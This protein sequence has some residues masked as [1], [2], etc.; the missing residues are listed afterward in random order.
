MDRKYVSAMNSFNE[1]LNSQSHLLVKI[2]CFGSVNSFSWIQLQN[3]LPPCKG[4]RSEG[5]HH[6][7]LFKTK[8]VTP[9][10]L[11]SE[12]AERYA[13]IYVKTLV[14]QHFRLWNPQTP[15][16]PKFRPSNRHWVSEDGLPEPSSLRDPGPPR[17]KPPLPPM[18][19]VPPQC[20][21]PHPPLLPN[22][23]FTLRS[24]IQKANPP[25]PLPPNGLPSAHRW[26]DRPHLL[27]DIPGR[28]SHLCG[29]SCHQPACTKLC[30]PIPPS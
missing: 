22:R 1:V 27:Q 8:P 2:K 11:N 6:A 18:L 16:D 3:F 9:I 29:A 17:P 10:T 4:I 21:P 15:E 28:P 30:P 24:P 19:P 20:P 7:G 12:V 26:E 23:H 25:V 14:S 5:Y 13:P